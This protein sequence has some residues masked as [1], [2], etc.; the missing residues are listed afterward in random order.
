MQTRKKF[1][2][3]LG[4]GHDLWVRGA[5]GVWR[6]AINIRSK[7]LGGHQNSLGTLYRGSYF[8]LL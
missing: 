2:H 3:A 1:F 4:T 5:M 8:D 6:G 7:Y